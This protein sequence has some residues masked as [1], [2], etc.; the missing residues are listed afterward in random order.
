MTAP[1]E[2]TSVSFPVKALKIIIHDLQSG[3]DAATI[4][5]QGNTVED[6]DSDDGVSYSPFMRCSTRLIF[7][8]ARMKI[9]RKK[10][11]WTRDSKKTNLL[12]FLKCLDRRAWLSTMMNFW[13]IMMM[14]ILRTILF[15][16]WTCRLVITFSKTTSCLKVYLKAHLVS[17]LRDYATHNTTNFYALI[18]QLTAQEMLVVRQAVC[19]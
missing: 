7:G 18:D 11:S 10:K 3:G 15:R 5:A 16:R 17:F 13:M 19:G 2:F 12:S 14:R 9:G 4:S 8:N 6:V 1:H